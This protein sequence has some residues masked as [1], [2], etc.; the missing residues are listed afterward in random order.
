MKNTVIGILAHVD[1]GKTTLA[2]SILY[3]CQK[4]RKPGRVD[5]GDTV[6]DHYAVERERGIT[7][8]SKQAQITYGGRNFT[9][10]DTPGHVDFS[11]ETERTLNVL[12]A[13]ILV[14]S[15]KDRV[16]AHT[17]TLWRL[18][19]HYHVPVFLFVNK[20]DQ[21]GNDPDAI[22][23]DLRNR[24]DSQI[25]SFPSAPEE[26]AKHTPSDDVWYD[27]LSMCNEEMME[28]FLENGVIETSAIAAAVSAREVF[29]VYYGSALHLQG[30]KT[31]LNGIATYLPAGEKAT[32]DVPFSGRV[33]KISRENGTRLT[34]VR[35]TAG[36]L[37]VKDA[38]TYGEYTEKIN[39][40]RI[41]HGS[42][43]YPLE[44]VSAG[45]I[46]C[47]T[48]PNHTVAGQGLGADPVK[49]ESYLMPVLTYQVIPP[50]G[51][52]P[53]AALEQL[54]SLNEEIPELN[55]TWKENSAGIHVQVMGEV[56]IE[57]LRKPVAKP[58]GFR[59]PVRL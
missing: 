35:I 13:A 56:Q 39:Q 12:D 38:L 55:V 4:I 49:I 29:P 41:Y 3:T 19:R 25:I 30:I 57:I 22:L 15:A 8:F 43:F 46:C 14:I 16:Q 6:L 59:E 52:D 53:V 11:V 54:R 42:D 58:F 32:E 17:L 50:S 23:S 28:S 5:H 40:I 24:L 27:E 51:T 10:L 20:M 26:G 9:L 7:V 2:E 48:G 34:H 45:D 21:P 33:F 44:K 18:L 37:Q 47:L 36:T 31:L 1:A